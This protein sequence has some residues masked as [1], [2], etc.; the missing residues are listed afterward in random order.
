MKKQVWSSVYCFIAVFS[1]FLFS[2]VCVP[3]IINSIKKNQL[4][5][6][7]CVFILLIAYIFLNRSNNPKGIFQCCFCC[8]VVTQLFL[9]YFLMVEYSTWDVYAVTKTARELA[10]D[11]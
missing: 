7:L 1:A 8:M 9:G 2:S 4:L 5:I 11:S 10:Y 3:V 6:P